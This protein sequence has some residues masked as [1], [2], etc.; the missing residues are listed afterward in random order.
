MEGVDDDGRV[1]EVV[2]RDVEVRLP[3]VDDEVAD[4]GP[5]LGRRLVE[6]CYSS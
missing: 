3:H 4:P 6:E 1:R 5:L 2:P